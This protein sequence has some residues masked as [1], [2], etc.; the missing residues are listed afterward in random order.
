MKDSAPIKGGTK[1]SLL[2]DHGEDRILKQFELQTYCISDRSV[3]ILK[4]H[5]GI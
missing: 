3:N 4:K 1:E 2:E 5:T